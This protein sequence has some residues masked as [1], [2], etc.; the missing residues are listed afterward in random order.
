MEFKFLRGSATANN[1]DEFNLSMR[2]SDLLPSLGRLWQSVPIVR[3]IASPVI[4]SMGE[5]HHVTGARI[6]F[7]PDGSARAAFD[8]MSTLPFMPG[9]SSYRISKADMERIMGSGAD[10]R[11]LADLIRFAQEHLTSLQIT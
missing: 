9:Q 11:T 8:G 1:L 2:P 6:T 5:A 10:S 3:H 7:Y 4:R